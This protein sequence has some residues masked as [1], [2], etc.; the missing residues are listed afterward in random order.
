LIRLLLLLLIRLL[1]QVRLLLLRC[2]LQLPL[3]IHYLRSVIISLLPQKMLQS[4]VGCLLLINEPLIK[5][6]LH[7][8]HYPYYPR[9]SYPLNQIL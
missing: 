8:L 6:V 2:I 1:L 7:V 9:V 4:I 3:Q 5:S